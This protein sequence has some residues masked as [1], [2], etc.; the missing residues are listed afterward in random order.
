MEREAAI[1]ALADQ[2]REAVSRVNTLSCELADHG[3][4]VVIDYTLLRR[5]GATHKLEY[6]HV[7]V[8]MSQKV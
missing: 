7:V 5:I 3:V 1:K 4:S 6:A 2:M 8:T